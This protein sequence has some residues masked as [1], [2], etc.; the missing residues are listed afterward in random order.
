MTCP[1]L[2]IMYLRGMLK[3]FHSNRTFV[4]IL[5]PV[6]IL[7]FYFL[8]DIFV[9]HHIEKATS[10]GLWGELEL[11]KGLLSSL[12][13]LFLVGAGAILLNNLY[14]RN[15]FIE[16][17]NYLP[18]ILYVL[19]LSFFHAFYF[20]DGIGIAQFFLL[21]SLT[22]LF[23]LDQK[24]D[25]RKTVFNAAFYYGVASTF[26]PLL[27][28][29]FPFLFLIIWVNR[30]FV[31]RESL[32]TI[33]GLLV[34]LLYAALY[35]YFFGVAIGLTDLNS[36]SKE[37]FTIDMWVVIGGIISLL[38]IGL[39]QSLQKMQ[40]GSIRIKKIFRMLLLLTIF[41]FALFLLD[42][43]TYRKVQSM[44]LLF[45]PLTLVFPYSFGEK[46]PELIP[47]ILF[48]LIFAIAVSKFFIPFNDL[49]F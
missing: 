34:P 25:G 3:A 2:S 14:N 39:K 48:Y 19:F 12:P 20:I 6:I 21:I 27:Y 36:S 9:Y 15:E 37:I 42:V 41:L 29:G 18:S 7:A 43:L 8:N 24:I 22:Q 16:K 5:I 13:A 28:M 17:N 35:S 49:A 33:T 32:L 31:L 40:V 10:F 47:S 4:L 1:I 38:I 44:S 30:P 23:L 26:F 11:K 45:I 46:K